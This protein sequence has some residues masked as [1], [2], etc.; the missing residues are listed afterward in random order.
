MKSQPD[1]SGAS[2]FV[3]EAVRNANSQVPLLS[4]NR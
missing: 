4:V 2:D 3:A 1:T